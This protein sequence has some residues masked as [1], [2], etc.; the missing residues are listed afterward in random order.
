M[1]KVPTLLDALNLK[2][3]A[4][5]DVEKQ[6]LK[7]LPK[8]IKLTGDTHLRESLAAHLEETRN[9]VLRLDQC[10]K[11]VE[12]KPKRI[13]VE[14]IRGIV[15]D[16]EWA[17]KKDMQPELRDAL[18]IAFAQYVEHYEMAG[19]GAAKNWATMLGFTDMALLLSQ[20]L[21]EEK[22]ADEKLTMIADA[23]IN[24]RAVRV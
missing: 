22:T 15:S 7:A 16:A 5:H 17:L 11:L 6:L 4:L 13:R 2:I 18:I 14:G 21:E 8:M 1:K 3:L 23:S 24:R 10:L 20:T 19:Y 9:H 12:L